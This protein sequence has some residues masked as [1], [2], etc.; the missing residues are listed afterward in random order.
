MGRKEAGPEGDDML[1]SEEKVPGSNGFSQRRNG[2]EETVSGTNAIKL[3]QIR[4]SMGK[5]GNLGN[6]LNSLDSH[7]D[8][9][10]ALT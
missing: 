1:F 5:S 10:N 6:C 3:R 9:S 8:Q 7:Y 4:S 2:D